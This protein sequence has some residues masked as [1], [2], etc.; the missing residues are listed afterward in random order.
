LFNE[1]GVEGAEEKMKLRSLILG[2]AAA[3][4]FAGGAFAETPDQTYQ[5]QLDQYHQQQDDYQ[6]RMRNY[7][8][9]MNQY[10]YDRAHPAWWWRTAYFHAA[11]E[12]YVSYRERN[13]IGAEV[14]ERD[15]RVIGHIQDID[16]TPSGRVDRVEI[17]LHGDRAAWVDAYHIRY[18]RTD[19][20]AFVDMS[21]GE[22]YDRARDNDYRP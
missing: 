9:R 14:D 12:W 8:A 15:G 2:S 4:C 22:L 21:P 1:T 3:F 18:D 16:R 17:A 19:R 6:D 5:E 20:I 7:H 13:L 10:E 11:P